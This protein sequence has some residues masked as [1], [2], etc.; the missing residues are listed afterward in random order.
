M[1]HA[2][3]RPVEWTSERKAALLADFEQYIDESDIPI[4]AEFCSKHKTYKQR[5]YEYEEFSDSIR[6]CIN[7]KESALE[8][9]GLTNQ[10][11][12]TMAIFSLKQLGWKD[13]IEQTI[14][15]AEGGPIEHSL[16]TVSFEK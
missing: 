16:V 3:G 1:A 11:N 9:L 7:K 10:I 15:G 6:R 8:S 12:T 13:K 5:L 2:G 4:V 14:T